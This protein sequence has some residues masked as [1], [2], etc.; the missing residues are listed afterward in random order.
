MA[1]HTAD[2]PN[3]GTLWQQAE[4][5]LGFQPPEAC[6]EGTEANLKLLEQHQ[7]VLEDCLR[8]MGA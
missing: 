6:R 5:R 4:E 8:D 2:K 1:D 7:R 3:S